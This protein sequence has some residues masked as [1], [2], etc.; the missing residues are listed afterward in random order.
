MKTSSR[1]GFSLIELMAVVLTIAVFVIPQAIITATD[2]PAQT[3][4]GD[5]I[6][7]SAASWGKRMTTGSDELT[8]P[9]PPIILWQSQRR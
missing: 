6:C 1:K 4:R 3:T 2:I 5:T 7:R 8:N 9:V